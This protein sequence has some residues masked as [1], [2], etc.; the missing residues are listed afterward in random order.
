MNKRAVRF[1]LTAVMN[2]PDVVRDNL[3][4]I[5]F[6]RKH[7][8][9]VSIDLDGVAA[10][11]AYYLEENGWEVEAYDADTGELVGPGELSGHNVGRIFCHQGAILT[12]VHEAA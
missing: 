3:I 10:K 8:T 6:H 1:D 9:S 2:L 11:Y 5:T 7:G 12:I 4:S